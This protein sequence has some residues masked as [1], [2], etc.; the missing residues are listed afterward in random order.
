MIKRINFII[1]V[2]DSGQIEL[3]NAIIECYEKEKFLC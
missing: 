1:G 3:I 2:I